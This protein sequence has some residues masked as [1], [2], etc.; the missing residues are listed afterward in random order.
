MCSGNISAAYQGARASKEASESQM[1]MTQMGIAEQR[2]QYDQTRA[3]QMPWM[4]AGKNALTELVAK[5]KAGPGEFTKSPGYDFRLAEGE[6]ALTRNAAATGGTQSGRTMKALTK[7][8]QD[9][10]T[11]DYDNFLRRYY[12]S[13]NPYQALSG[14]GQT[15]AASIGQAGG[16]SANTISALLNAQGNAKATGIMNAS[17]AM[18]SGINSGMNNLATGAYMAWKNGAFNSGSTYTGTPGS[19]YGDP[20]STPVYK[21]TASSM[22]FE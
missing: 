3:D 18:T 9:Y 16:N 14:T 5:V 13:L 2:R 6:K 4:E 19:T 11:N 20:G 12:E 10:A 22:S 17:N 15:T 7:Y 1:Q 21:D 8:G